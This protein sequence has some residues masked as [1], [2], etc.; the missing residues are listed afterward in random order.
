M[1]YAVTFE[2]PRRFIMRQTG[3]I[4]ATESRAALGE[5]G[6]HPRFGP[7]TT[8]LCIVEGATDVPASDELAGLAATLKGL[9]QRGLAGFVIVAEPGYVFGVARMFSAASEML[10]VRVEVMEH[11]AEARDILDE[12]EQVAL[13]QRG[14][15]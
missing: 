2:E 1:P 12:I 4:P 7:G 14:S 3:V 8:V 5:I 15:R 6:S 10:G 9:V 13:R 11:E